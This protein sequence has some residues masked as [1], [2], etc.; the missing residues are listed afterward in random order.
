MH[1]QEQKRL[2]EFIT[3]ANTL[4]R[5]PTVAVAEPD[6]SAVATAGLYCAPGASLLLSR[7]MSV[8]SFALSV[9]GREFELALADCSMRALTSLIL[10]EISRIASLPACVLAESQLTQSDNIF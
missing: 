7:L 8:G 2:G 5:L 3:Q 1:R 10:P 6:G 4:R 9:A